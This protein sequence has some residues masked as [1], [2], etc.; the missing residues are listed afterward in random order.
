MSLART[1]GRMLQQL[2]TAMAR[3]SDQLLLEQLGIGLAQYKI[4][5]ILHTQSPLQQKAIARSLSQTEASISRQ[6]KLL[7]YAHLVS[8]ER[9]P[10]NLREHLVSL[11]LRGQRVTEAADE[12]IADYHEKFFRVLSKKQQKTLA[13]LLNLLNN[14]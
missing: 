10:A 13:D 1:S 5:T 7:H 14:H 9:N 6:I 11:T 2:V 4:L 3:E 8:V 12:V